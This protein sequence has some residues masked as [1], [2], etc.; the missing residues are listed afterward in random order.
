MVGGQGAGQPNLAAIKHSPVEQQEEQQEEQ[1]Q[2]QGQAPRGG[3]ERL[4]APP[5]P[6]LSRVGL[7]IIPPAPGHDVMLTVRR[8]ERRG[9]GQTGGSGSS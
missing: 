8:R 2:E 5:P 7:G 9:P 6:D 4:L 3:R 1:Q